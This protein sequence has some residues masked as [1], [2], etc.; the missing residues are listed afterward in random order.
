MVI[1]E[2]LFEARHAQLVQRSTLQVYRDLATRQ[3]TA[4]RHASCRGANTRGI[5]SGEEDEPR[6]VGDAEALNA[7][8]R[9][10]GGLD[11]RG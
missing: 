4:S 7:E 10:D 3:S 9:A 1:E 5:A 2:R 8:R 11:D 6:A